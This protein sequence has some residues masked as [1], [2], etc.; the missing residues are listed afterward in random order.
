MGQLQQLSCLCFGELD[1]QGTL[2]ASA[3]RWAEQLVRLPRLRHVLIDCDVFD[4][5]HPV[6]RQQLPTTVSV[7]YADDGYL[8][9][10][11]GF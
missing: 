7:E 5:M 10:T 9:R 1:R 2:A 11:D 8:C 6:V 3:K 4:G